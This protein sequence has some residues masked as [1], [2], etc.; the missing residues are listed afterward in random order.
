MVW[1]IESRGLAE[2]LAEASM[3]QTYIDAGTVGHLLPQARWNMDNGIV[4]RLIEASVGNSRAHNLARLQAREDVDAG[5]AKSNQIQAL[6]GC[7]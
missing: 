3:T 2:H 5:E 7:S 4:K 6:G 1:T